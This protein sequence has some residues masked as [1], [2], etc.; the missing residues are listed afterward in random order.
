MFDFII[1]LLGG[2]TKNNVKFIKLDLENSIYEYKKKSF[3]KGDLVYV[4]SDK[5]TLFNYAES[6]YLIEPYNN[7][8]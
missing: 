8:D 6:Y 3:R 1:K 2:Y 7:G 4:I 5:Y